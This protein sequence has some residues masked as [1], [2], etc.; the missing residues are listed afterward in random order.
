MLAALRSYVVPSAPFCALLASGYFY[1]DILDFFRERRRS[2]RLPGPRDRLRSDPSPA[3]GSE[4]STD[5]NRLV[6]A[7]KGNGAGCRST[8]RPARAEGFTSTCLQDPGPFPVSSTAPHYRRIKSESQGFFGTG[9]LTAP[10]P[11]NIQNTRPNWK[12]HLR[13]PESPTLP[14][15]KKGPR[16]VSAKRPA[17]TSFGRLVSL[18]TP[19]ILPIS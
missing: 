15:I 17:A 9:R 18:V 1:R 10:R 12:N 6:R 4:F 19:Y 7:M 16:A 14:P 13:W 5:G 8:L 3:Y 2:S 11:F